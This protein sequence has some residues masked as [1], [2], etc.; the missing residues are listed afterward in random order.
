L[1]RVLRD[2]DDDDERD[3]EHPDE[4]EVDESDTFPENSLQ[5]IL[6]FI[7]PL[8]VNFYILVLKK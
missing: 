4:E 7:S 3:G 1:F 2:D 8:Q 5:E 6:N